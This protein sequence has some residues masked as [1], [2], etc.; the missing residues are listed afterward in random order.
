VRARSQP[1]VGVPCVGMLPQGRVRR[2]VPFALGGLALLSVLSWLF[3]AVV[4]I[5]DRYRVGHGQGVWMALAQYADHGVLYPPLYDG[6]HFGGTRYMPLQIGVNALGAKLTGE[7]LTSGKLIALVT[8]AVLLVLVFRLLRRSGC[9]AAL[10]GA[11]TALIIVTEGGL[12][13]GT[14]LGGDVLPAVLQVGVIG[15][16]ATEP[17]DPRKRTAAALLGALALTAKFTAVWGVLAVLSWYIV[18]DL[19]RAAWRFGLTFVAAAALLL[20]TAEIL[21][22][23]RMS[24]NILALALSGGVGPKAL[25]RAPNQLITNLG[26]LTLAGWILVPIAAVAILRS[27]SWRAITVTQW[28]LIWSFVTTLAVLSDLGTGYNQ[29]VDVVALLVLVVGAFAARLL[30][31]EHTD[32]VS[33]TLIPLT[34]VWGL[35]TG[36]ALTVLVDVKEVIADPT[37]SGPARPLEGTVGPGETLLSED[38]GIPVGLERTPIILDPF[39]LPRLAASRPET[40]DVLVASIEAKEWDLVVLIERAEGND[41]W[42]QDYHLGPRVIEAIRRSYV[43]DRVVDGFFVYRPGG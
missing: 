34:I 17:D 16:I 2:T 42:W 37:S 11:L 35:A 23:G 9:P 14:S 31:A 25:G 1:A 28:A 29:M 32:T 3:L 18:N 8:T 27:G 33:S 12:H 38:P 6:E 10:A 36:L 39:M 41:V 21:S 24:E 40:I 20:G 22:G 15:L 26:E 4:H 7:Y 43:F 13:V 5:D 30:R 19:R